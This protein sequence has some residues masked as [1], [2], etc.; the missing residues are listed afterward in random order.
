MSD[1]VAVVMDRGLPV[2]VTSDGFELCSVSYNFTVVAVTQNGT[3]ER[4]E[5]FYPQPVD[6]LSKICSFVCSH[7]HLHCTMKPANRYMWPTYRTSLVP[8]L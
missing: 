2:T 1:V 6:F 8:R 3:G 5:V 7:G 4:S